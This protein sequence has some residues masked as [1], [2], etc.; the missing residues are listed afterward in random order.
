[1]TV[2]RGTPAAAGKSEDSEDFVTA[3]QVACLVSAR[4]SDA[5]ASI[6]AEAPD[7]P[8]KAAASGDSGRA[9]GHEPSWEPDEKLTL[10]LHQNAPAAAR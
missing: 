3:G 9:A 10:G 2:S 5:P 8:A 6:I 7:D 1:M 4:S